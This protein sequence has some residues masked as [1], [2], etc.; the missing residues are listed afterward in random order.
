MAA[1]KAPERR[2]FLLAVL[3]LILRVAPV[4]SL[5]AGGGFTD[6]DLKGPFEFD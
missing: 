1:V 6:K 2:L 4:P 5:R 3:G